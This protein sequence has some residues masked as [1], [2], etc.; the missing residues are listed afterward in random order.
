[1]SDYPTWI[2]S[3]CGREHGKRLPM[4]ASYHTGD[5]GWCRA[6]H[7]PVTEPRDFGYPDPP[8]KRRGRGPGKKPALVHVS[9]RVP[10]HVLDYYGGDTRAMRDAWVAYVESLPYPGMVTELDKV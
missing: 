7:I 10:Q 8:N 5:C 6:E 9:L 3:P 4:L 1:M 2:C